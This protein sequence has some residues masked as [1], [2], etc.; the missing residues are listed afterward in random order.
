QT[1]WQ[2]R[3]EPLSPDRE[4]GTE[5]VDLPLDTAPQPTSPLANRLTPHCELPRQRLRLG[6]NPP[7]EPGGKFYELPPDLTPQPTSPPANL[8][9]PYRQPARHPLR[10]IF[11][12]PRRAVTQP[13]AQPRAELAATLRCPVHER[14]N[15]LV[16]RLVPAARGS[17]CEPLTD[18]APQFQKPG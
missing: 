16:R 15:P 11:G 18:R 3:S 2:R 14:R 9:S 17:P 6:N 5:L 12:R 1:R 7:A 10:R 4:P 8:G 13:L